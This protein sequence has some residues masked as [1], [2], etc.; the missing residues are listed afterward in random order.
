MLDQHK[1]IF[2]EVLDDADMAALEEQPEATLYSD[3]INNWGQNSYYAWVLYGAASYMCAIY[4]IQRYYF[5]NW[6]GT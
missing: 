2:Q 3:E 1:I 4:W 5:G 6:Y